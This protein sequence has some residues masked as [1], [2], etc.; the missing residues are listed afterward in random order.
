MPS[1]IH[2]RRSIHPAATERNHKSFIG[3]LD[4][5][6]NDLEGAW[7]TAMI[8]RTPYDGP[9]ISVRRATDNIEMDIGADATG[10]LNISTLTS[11]IGSSDWRLHKIYDQSG[12]GRH[13]A[14]NSSTAQ[15]QGGIDEHGLAF[16]YNPHEHI[17]TVELTTSSL[18]LSIR[19]TTQW[20]VGSAAAYAVDLMTIR[21]N[22]SRRLTNFSNAVMLDI[23]EVFG[24]FI[25]GTNTSV[26]SL[27]GQFGETSRLHTGLSTAIGGST[28]SP[29][30][31]I[32]FSAG[33]FGGGPNWSH[34]SRW[35]AGAVWSS[36]LGDARVDTFQAKA[37]LLFFAS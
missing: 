32:F 12:H 3:I 31:V 15:P 14:Q 7:S 22:G 13:L 28:A 1:P 24:P 26:Y 34:N 29:D 35:Y 4:E 16:A 11:F 33:N 27:A 18:N 30:S 10:H 6:S 2:L 36:D 37:K 17:G 23:P 20:A 5:A 25:D 9:L 21:G 8:L 19:E